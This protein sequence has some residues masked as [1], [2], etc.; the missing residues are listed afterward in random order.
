MDKDKALDEFIAAAAKFFRITSED[1]PP[2]D[3]QQRD[4]KTATYKAA[5]EAALQ[6]GLSNHDLN[7]VERKLIKWG[8]NEVNTL[9]RGA[10]VVATKDFGGILRRRIP[11]GTVGVVVQPGLGRN[12]RVSFTLQATHEKDE[13][14]EVTVHPIDPIAI[15]LPV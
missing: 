10:K 1:H 9:P 8:E 13:Q 11:A 15:A 6:A 14:V 3:Q 2:R 7:R 5:R 4:R 12:M